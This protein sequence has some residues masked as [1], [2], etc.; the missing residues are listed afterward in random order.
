MIQPGVARR[1]AQ[2]FFEAATEQSLIERC[3]Q[4][5]AVVDEAMKNN[6]ALLT[7]LS[8]PTISVAVK[9]EHLK[10]VFGPF[11]HAVT[12]NLLQLLME[13]GREKFISAIA[14]YY[15]RLADEAQGRITAYVETAHV[16]ADSEVRE[17][18][19]RLSGETGRTYAV[20]T[21]LT[22]ELIGGVRVR[23]GDH[24]I[25]ATVKGRLTQFERQLDRVKY[26]R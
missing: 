7:L 26:G 6:P 8:H 9:K 12:L 17:I 13:R 5:L 4:D 10:A 20:E 3:G 24:V 23:I 2:A 11:V 18:E 19:M 25:D 14:D 21:A 22:P 1:Y 16:L 15:K